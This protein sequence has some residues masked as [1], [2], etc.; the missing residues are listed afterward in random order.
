MG[1]AFGILFP[2][3]MVLG[4]S[5]FPRKPGH[6]VEFWGTVVVDSSC[7]SDIDRALALARSCPDCRYLYR[8]CRLFPRSRP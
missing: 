1:F 2:L 6:L 7:V 3:G 5:F 4:V 8:R